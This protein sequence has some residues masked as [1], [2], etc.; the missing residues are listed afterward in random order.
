MEK[1]L[2]EEYY[3]AIAKNAHER[4]IKGEFSSEEMRIY[5]KGKID[6]LKNALRCMGE[7]HS[8][9]DLIDHAER[10]L[11]FLRMERCS[12]KLMTE[13]G[14]S[15][16]WDSA[17]SWTSGELMNFVELNIQDYR[18]RLKK[19]REVLKSQNTLLKNLQQMEIE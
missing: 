14:N 13:K 8:V 10:L 7:K 18:A 9:Q 15:D 5:E 3:V 17:Y 16:I 11:K 12:G 19:A 4:R 2:A 1:H 6:A